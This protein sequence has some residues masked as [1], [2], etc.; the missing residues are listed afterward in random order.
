MFA[1]ILRVVELD[2]RASILHISQLSMNRKNRAFER[3]YGV[4]LF[5]TD[6]ILYTD[7]ESVLI[8]GMLEDAY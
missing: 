8:R 7:D 3:T 6:C 5:S 4:A 2:V 1:S